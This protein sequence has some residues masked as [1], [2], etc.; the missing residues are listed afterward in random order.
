MNHYLKTTVLIVV[1]G[2]MTVFSTVIKNKTIKGYYKC[3]VFMSC[4]TSENINPLGI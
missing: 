1:L 4:N 2:T 3:L